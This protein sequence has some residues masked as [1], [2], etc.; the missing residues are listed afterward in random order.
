MLQTGTIVAGYRVDG[1]LGQGGMA[2]V[3]RA[4]Q[5]SLDRVVAL[6]LL[7]AELSDDPSFRARFKREGQLQAGLDHQHIVPVY[8]AG[9]SEHG[10][11]L[12]MR[13]IPGATLK[14]LILGGDLNPRRTLRLLMQVALALD[15]AHAKGLIHRDVKPQNILIDRDDHVYLADFGLTKSQDDTAGLTGTGQFLGTIDYVSP[16]Q[17]QGLPA[18]AASDCYALTAVLYE[19]LT[20]EVPFVAPN[21][22]A[23]LHAHVVKPPPRVTD[24]RPELPAALDD[25]IAAGMAKDPTARPSPTSELIRS[26]ARAVAPGSL[27]AVPG[28]QT[29]LSDGQGGSVMTL[30]GGPAAA[31]RLTGTPPALA[32]A[33]A[34]H[35]ATLAAAQRRR[36][37]A[38]VAA[39]LAAALF[40]AAL[41]A[42][43]LVGKGGQSSG[44]GRLTSSALAGHV[45]LN[46]PSDW[47][48]ASAPPA[49]AGLA[50]SEPL[51]LAAREAGNGLIAGEIHN[52]SGSTL[53]A[54][55]FR[56]RVLGA[57]PSAEPMKLGTV[58]AYRYPALR[59]AGASGALTLY[60]VPT[61]A[62]VATV[63]CKSARAGAGAF[64][65]QC[66]RAVSTLRLVGAVAYP[67]TPIAS[68]AE[69]LS[70]AFAQLGRAAPSQLGVLRAPPSTAAQAQAARQ[71]AAAYAKAAGELSIV[72]VS[73]LVAGAH[74]MLVTALTALSRGYGRAAGGALSG[75]TSAYTGA[76]A[77]LARARSSLEDALRALAALGYTV[78]H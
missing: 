60:A 26:A 71:L 66:A 19:C 68:Y 72:A 33:S 42:G 54:R 40:V 18:T 63:I 43:F 45:L 50:F 51:S 23:A 15:T 10:L 64:Q 3:Y 24:V 57:L 31:T 36:G 58:E 20:G 39:P 78:A 59:A 9:D 8:E 17:I 65:S 73:P 30:A 2:I 53:L 25:V 52:A 47:R 11:F 37:L 38:G 56:S 62:G 27:E 1:L 13:L 12:A 21:E 34:G 48:L 14:Q 49:V 28:Q 75:N 16:E 22:A 5:L 46:Y 69:R 35:R 61:S 32:S 44:A 67:L 4:T 55:S 74:E 6:K 7:A 29:V 70:A 41:V 77:E 76:R